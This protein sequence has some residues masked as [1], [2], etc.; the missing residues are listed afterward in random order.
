VFATVRHRTVRTKG[1][2]SSTT[3]K[4]TNQLPKV[5]SGARFNDGIEVTQVLA[6]YAA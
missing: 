6:N 2:L 4:L 1:S 5:F 3:A